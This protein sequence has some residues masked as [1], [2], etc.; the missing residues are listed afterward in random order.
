M[1]ALYDD[2][3]ARRGMSRR[4][5]RRDGST[6]LTIAAPAD[7][8]YARIADVTATGQR[9]LECRAAQWLPGAEPG[10]VGARFRGHNRSGLAR[11]S[12]TCEVVEA[13]PGVTFAFRTLPHRIDR[14]RADS[15]IWRYRL[16]AEGDS[17]IVTHEYEIVQLPTAFF[18][19]L[20]GR[21][22]PHH[23]DMR[24]HMAHTLNALRQELESPRPAVGPEDNAIN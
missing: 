16:R 9:S 21:I 19:A 15:T 1:G 14:S 7:A 22:L 13:E 24:P 12:R 10:T 18:R 3:R 17:T 4:P 8:V 11:W 23:R 6:T 2:T 20:Y 5:W